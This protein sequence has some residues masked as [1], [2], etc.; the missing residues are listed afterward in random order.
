VT[1]IPF[2]GTQ[3]A[4]GDK[5]IQFCPPEFHLE[6][7]KTAATALKQIETENRRSTPQEQRVLARYVGWGGM[8]NAFRQP[9]TK[10]FKPDWKERGEQLEAFSTSTKSSPRYAC[11]WLIAQPSSFL[12]APSLRL[13][14]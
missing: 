7:P 10:E 1:I 3:V 6:A 8:A 11:G 4:L 2:F 12:T 14:S 5:V 13:V 9:D